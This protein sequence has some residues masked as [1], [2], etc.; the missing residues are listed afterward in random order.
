MKNA[1]G[2]G[3]H[4][5]TGGTYQRKG[6]SGQVNGGPAFGPP[7]NTYTLDQRGPLGPLDGY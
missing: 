5:T 6:G 7:L 3:H 4:R 2:G 1:K